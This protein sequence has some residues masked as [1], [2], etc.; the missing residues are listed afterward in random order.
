MLRQV[1]LVLNAETD[2]QT[3][4]RQNRA[5]IYVLDCKRMEGKEMEF[6]LDIA[7]AEK[8]VDLVVKD[9]KAKGVF[10]RIDVGES[11]SA[12][13]AIC[14]AVRDVPPICGAVID[15][16]AFCLDCPYCTSDGDGKWR[17]V[18]RD[19]AQLHSLLRTL[20]ANGIHAPIAGIC[21]ARGSDQL[22]PRQR[23]VFA[24]AISLGFFEFPRRV[25]LTQLSEALGVKPST[26]S[27]LLRAAERKVIA[28]YASDM[29]I[30]P[31]RR[32]DATAAGGPLP[33][34]NLPPTRNA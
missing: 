18:V 24:R 3:V 5:E 9:L 6:L 32:P 34:N 13:R 1:S 31:S 29:K 30:G 2:V 27:Q 12:S 25:S 15:S 4:A 26:L 28:K 20:E 21:D 23:E 14:A 33:T 8:H 11:G 19:S 16:G 22:T 17:V 10:K 7:S